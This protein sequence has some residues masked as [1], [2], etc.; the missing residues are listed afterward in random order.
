MRWKIGTD[1][2]GASRGSVLS[3]RSYL[4][5]SMY[6]RLSLSLYI[7]IYIYIYMH[8][9]LWYIYIK[10]CIF[11]TF[12]NLGKIVT[13]I[14][15]YIYPTHTL[16]HTHI[17]THTLIYIYIYI[18]IY[19]AFLHFSR[20]RNNRYTYIYIYIYPT[21]TCTHTH[22]HT[23]IYIYIYILSDRYGLAMLILFSFVTM[24]AFFSPN[25]T[26]F[27]KNNSWINRLDPSF[28]PKRLS[29]FNTTDNS[30]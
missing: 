2:E 27:T 13:R 9:Y 7:Y 1:D 5:I 12:Q 26:S 8:T 15:I 20:F 17:H 14:Y 30:N 19:I 6:I 3:V 10:D 18:Y 29:D 28:V 11:S 25:V 24:P 23:H 21:H 4:N 16:A 22:T